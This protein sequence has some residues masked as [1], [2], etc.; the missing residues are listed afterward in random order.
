MIKEILYYIAIAIIIFGFILS[1]FELFYGTWTVILG[2][3]F[4]VALSH[5]KV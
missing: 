2:F 4:G 5:F 1:C 3:A